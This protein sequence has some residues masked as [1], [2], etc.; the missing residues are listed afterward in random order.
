MWCTG[1]NM[2]VL[3]YP[4]S[5]QPNSR[6]YHRGKYFEQTLSENMETN[7]AWLRFAREV[8]GFSTQ[9][10][11]KDME[12]CDTTVTLRLLSTFPFLSLIFPFFLSVSVLLHPVH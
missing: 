5:Q 11:I 9:V 4:Q 7:T 2:S 12:E 8:Y 10:L 3:V 6:I 1:Q